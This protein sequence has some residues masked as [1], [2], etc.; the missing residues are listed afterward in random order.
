MTDFSLQ[1]DRLRDP[2]DLEA[3]LPPVSVDDHYRVT[4]TGA[5]EAD[6][7]AL[8]RRFA[9]LP[10]LTFRDQT[11]PSVDVW[12]GAGED[13]FR[14]V[15][16]DLLRQSDSPAALLAAKLSRQLLAGEEVALP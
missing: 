3:L 9:Y 16:F 6:I 10:N 11:R 14:G 7:A 5:G 13:S 4:L 1:A 12:E 2:E 15:Y 8:Q